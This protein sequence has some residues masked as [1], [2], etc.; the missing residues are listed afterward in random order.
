[1]LWLL[2]HQSPEREASKRVSLPKPSLISY[3]KEHLPHILHVGTSGT[4]PFLEKQTYSS[5]KTGLFLLLLFLIILPILP[6]PFLGVGG[7][8]GNKLLLILFF[9]VHFVFEGRTC[10]HVHVK[11]SA[12]SKRSNPVSAVILFL[13]TLPSELCD[14]FY[15]TCPAGSPMIIFHGSSFL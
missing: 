5:K 8:R 3:F 1:M 6:L 11:M 7:G 9:F 10:K 4:P 13:S 15:K 14:I 2:F 12:E